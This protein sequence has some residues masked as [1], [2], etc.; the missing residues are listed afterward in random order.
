MV[1]ELRQQAASHGFS[2]YAYCVMPDHVHALVMGLG[3]TSDLLMFIKILKQKTGYQFQ[4]KSHS[5]LWQKRFYDH[6]LRERDSVE[7]VAAYIWMNPVRAGLCKEAREYPHSG[8][9]VLD[10]T[11]ESAP[12][13]AWV[14]P[15][16][17]K[18]GGGEKLPA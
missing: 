2:V 4:R 1:E 12:V 14:P 17:A 6:I 7:R 9:F 5:S 11:R 13:E 3:A 18:A 16:K 15:W 10:W 8:S